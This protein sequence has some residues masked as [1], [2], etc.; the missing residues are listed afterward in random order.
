MSV[1]EL[2]DVI[3]LAV[4]VAHQL[5]TQAGWHVEEVK[6]TPPCAVED[7]RGRVVRIRRKGEKSVSLVYVVPPPPVE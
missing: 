4:P 7:N 5:L 1:K 3:G 2:P 6:A